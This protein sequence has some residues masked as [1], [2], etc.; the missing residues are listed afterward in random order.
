[1]NISKAI[2]GKCPKCEQGDVF[3][4]PGNIFKLQMP[5]MRKNC[6]HCNDHFEK[7]SGYFT[8][9]MYVSYALAVVELIAIFVVALFFDWSNQLLYLVVCVGISLMSFTN[10][11]YSRIFWMY[12]FVSKQE[13]S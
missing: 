2:Q 6:P 9:A 13:T 8:G 3:H 5:K 12:F 4:Q 1:M 10:F 7:E 11:K